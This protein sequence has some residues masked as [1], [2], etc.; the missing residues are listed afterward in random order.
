MPEPSTPAR[1]KLAI[2]VSSTILAVA[3]IS[4]IAFANSR[5][6]PPQATTEGAQDVVEEFIQAASAGDTAT[7]RSHLTGD[8]ERS[9]DETVLGSVSEYVTAKV[10]TPAGF[11][12]G[13]QQILE[14]GKKHRMFLSVTAAGSTGKIQVRT[15]LQYEDGRW[16]IEEIEIR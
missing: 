12:R 16:L 13:D 10:G 14:T 5:L 9:M 6:P 7:M 2:G 8:A 3:A 4:C 11:L 15:I 1:T